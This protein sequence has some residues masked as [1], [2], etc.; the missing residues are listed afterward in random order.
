MLAHK[1]QSTVE[2]DV[3]VTS[4]EGIT[5]YITTETAQTMA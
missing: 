2:A 4:Y 3:N 5:L 1:T